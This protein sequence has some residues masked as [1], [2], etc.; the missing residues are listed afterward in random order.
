MQPCL[1]LLTSA[2]RAEWV[3]GLSTL[4]KMQGIVSLN[5]LTKLLQVIILLKWENLVF[6]YIGGETLF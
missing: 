4:N 5:Y 3:Y 2:L 1:A 6:K